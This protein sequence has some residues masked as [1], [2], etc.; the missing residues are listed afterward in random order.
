MSKKQLHLK[1]TVAEAQRA[2]AIAAL[3]TGPK[4]SYDL[5]RIGLYQAPARILELRRR[6][7][8]IATSLVQ[9]TD[10]DG[11][12]HKGIA[13]YTLVAAPV[14]EASHADHE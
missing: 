14:K 1:S 9:I 12:P 4:T 11:Y 10:A 8:E 3:M 13:M 2:R 5:R 6:G 7:Y